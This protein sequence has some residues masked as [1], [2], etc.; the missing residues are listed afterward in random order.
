MLNKKLIILMAFFTFL[1]ITN[2]N[3]F[4][5]LSDFNNG[6][7][8]DG[9]FGFWISLVDT[10]PGTLISPDDFPDVGS[11][12][13]DVN[14]IDGT[15]SAQFDVNYFGKVGNI[16]SGIWD[17]NGTVNGALFIPQ[18]GDVLTFKVR[19]LIANSP[20]RIRFLARVFT[21][22][23]VQRIMKSDG[24]CSLGTAGHT[25]FTANDT[26]EQT[27][28]VNFDLEICD[29][30]GALDVDFSKGF[31][32]Q[33]RTTR[34]RSTDPRQNY[35]IIL[36]TVKLSRVVTVSL[37][38][39]FAS[40]T[41]ILSD[42]NFTIRTKVTNDVN[43]LVVPDATVE[44]RINSSPFESMNFDSS[45]QNYEKSFFSSV[46]RGDVNIF[47]RATKSGFV[48]G[49]LE[50]NIKI[51][52]PESQYLTV[53]PID[54]IESFSFNSVDFIPS[55][56]SDP[57]I[58]KVESSSIVSEVPVYKIINEL[59]D[60]R[61]YFVFTSPDNNGFAFNDTLTFGST[62]SNP[63][64]KI[65]DEDEEQYT[66]SFEDTLL[67]LETKFY[68]LDY[69][70]PFR[71]FFSIE[72]SPEWQETLKPNP[73]D[74]NTFL[75][76]EY[77]VSSFSNIRSL[78]IQHAPDIFNDENAV[79][80]F[81]F[82]AKSDVNNTL[83][84][85]G[86]TVNGVDNVTSV[87]LT[88]QYRTFSFTI[89]ATSFDSQ[90]LLK[91]QNTTSADILITDYALVARGFFTKRLKLFQADGSPLEVFLLNG[92]SKQFL[93][94]GNPFRIDTEAYD[95][96]GSLDKLELEAFLDGTGA[97]NKVKR[98][99]RGI[100][101]KEET[102][103]TFDD[104]FPPIIDLNGSVDNPD[105]PRSLVV[106]ANL[107]DEN[108][109]KVATQSQALTFLQFPF[110]PNDLIMNFFP[111]EKRLGKHPA[112]ILDVFIKDANILEAF[113]IRIFGDTNTVN[114]PNFRVTI[115]K[116]KDFRCVGSS[117]KIQITINDFVFEDIN[118]NQITIFALLNT[119][120]LNQDNNLTKVERR[121]FITPIEFTIAKIYQTFERADEIYRADEE[122]GLVLI[123][124]DTEATNIRGKI[125]VFLTLQACT[126]QF[127]NGTCI[128]QTTR[129]YPTSFVYDERFNANYFFFKHLYFLD[130]GTQLPL[131]PDNNFISFRATINDRTG[132][133]TAITPVLASRCQ[134]QD[135]ESTFLDIFGNPF[136]LVSFLF[137]GLLGLEGCDQAPTSSTQFDVITTTRN[138]DQERRLEIDV[139]HF[140]QKPSQTL[141]MC[142]ASDSNSNVIRNP[143]GQGVACL[144]LYEV[145]ES[146]IDGF[147]IR[148][149]NEFSDYSV[150]GK[151]RQYMEFFI[152]YEIVFINDSALMKNVLESQGSSITTVGEFFYEG[153][154][155]ILA[156]TLTFGRFS[157]QDRAR[158]ITGEGYI[159]NFG[160]DFDFT[161]AF[162]ATTITGVFFYE[163]KEIPVLNVRD[164]ENDSR[165]QNDI[166]IVDKRRFLDFLSANDVD[167]ENRFA[168]NQRG[169][170]LEVFFNDFSEPLV[171]T[172]ND[173]ILVIDQTPTNVKINRANLD[174]NEESG[175]FEVVPNDLKF[176]LN[177]TMFFNN[178]SGNDV[179]SLII[180]LVFVIRDTA[181]NTII[182]VAQAFI[183]DPFT[184]FTDYLL[185]NI[186]ILA[187]IGG[188]FV[189]LAIIRKNFTN[190]QGGN[191]NAFS[192]F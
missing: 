120:F 180:S 1:F 123:L 86:Q 63:V 37:V 23:G 188:V 126:A 56:E 53:T 108:G 185:D 2:V 125:E 47:I 100:E 148:I 165:I 24:T 167:F 184:A 173:G 97:N 13:Q 15:F 51:I 157:L 16:G 130:D 82:T 133:R 76:D 94:E 192:S 102:I 30:L 21:D 85:A 81:Q 191:G 35:S 119:E 110:F 39:E 7:F 26:S 106:R 162:S 34:L 93:Q 98:T 40:A 153:F 114:N 50:Q 67:P 117:C 129:Y 31:K 70:R 43:G 128:D 187:I 150:E 20:N 90:V 190:P 10:D 101:G 66:H 17:L 156:E 18:D 121:L 111:T 169:G 137:S 44:I 28:T 27:I 8:E 89:D 189:T 152:P 48:S 49:N 74:T 60:G 166:N 78:F 136:G 186:F 25:T 138:S 103:F 143:L 176:T 58:F 62:S 163:F 178:F 57:I 87:N 104:I 161:Q 124:K 45:A 158:L 55:I 5:V 6:G 61:Q 168:I 92:F 33:F 3:A 139:G 75:I 29:P 69:R 155:E 147:R 22:L 177:S 159:Q 41:T 72:D 142:E 116:D 107:F 115:F 105:P 91:T 65:W 149:G 135:F 11:F 181:S 68:L 38:Q 99:T 77:S 122:I 9:N 170:K 175:Q 144:E 79:F 160:A 4:T 59:T 12:V 83:I 131:L 36:D 32:I 134:D 42:S 112:G 146:S 164:F 84:F 140:V 141:F 96:N 127:P 88:D 183:N 64:Q 80:E 151:N 46:I 179:L 174:P 172:D 113:D 109:K 14:S 145:A 54:N 132:I 118:A 154:R 171:L 73:I 52:R 182:A 19:N 95:R 71:H